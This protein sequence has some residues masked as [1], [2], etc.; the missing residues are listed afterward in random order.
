MFC[1]GQTRLSHLSLSLSLSP[2]KNCFCFAFVL[3]LFLFLH[4]AGLELLPKRVLLLRRTVRVVAGAAK[5]RI[6]IATVGPMHE[7]LEASQQRLAS[8]AGTRGARL[9]VPVPG[10]HDLR[11]VQ[12]QG[13]GHGARVE[14][15]RS[16]LLVR[17]H[18]QLSGLEALVAQHAVQFDP[19]LLD[20]IL[21]GGVEHPYEEDGAGHVMR[22]CVAHRLEAADV[23]YCKALAQYLQLFGIKAF[24]IERMVSKVI[25]NGGGGGGQAAISRV[26]K[27][28]DDSTDGCVCVCVCVTEKRAPR[29]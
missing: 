29:E 9:H 15:A 10:L 21:I 13:P 6:T 22:P 18:E 16:V 3:L 23:P 26:K 17:E 19:G 27:K 4:E 11:R 8:A 25:Q 12:L 20:S 28:N 1:F 14:R 24:A 5:R 2:L 7:P